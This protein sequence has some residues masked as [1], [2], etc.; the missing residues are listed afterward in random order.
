M[1]ADYRRR[2]DRNLSGMV[3]KTFG[4]S[5]LNPGNAMRVLK[6]AYHQS[7][8]VKR[9]REWEKRGV[10][11]PPFMAISITHR[12]N[13]KCAGCYARELHPPRGE[14]LT[15]EEWRKLL[16]EAREMGVSIIMVLGGEPFSRSDLIQIARSFPEMIF[17]V[18]TNGS[19]FS[20]PTAEW[21]RRAGNIIP[22][23]GIEGSERDTDGRRGKGV[24]A[25]IEKAI[26][27]MRRHGLL[28]GASI[29]VSAPNFETV[30][31]PAFIRKLH[32]KGCRFFFTNEFLPA[33]S[34]TES[35]CLDAPKKSALSEYLTRTRRN[36]PAI[37]V[38]FPGDESVFGGCLSAG[39]GIMHVSAEGRFEPCPFLPFAETNS[40]T[41]TLEEALRSPL[42]TA[43]RERTAG[44]DLSGG[45]CELWNNRN[46]V[47][48]LLPE[49]ELP[50]QP[51]LP[52]A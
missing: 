36:L 11:V 41:H 19:Y 2:I 9:R 49:P 37:F 25:G 31:D 21:I 46:W 18:F 14:E 33:Q 6:A 39:R 5:L 20:D 22:V 48:S 3:W 16:A 28:F 7:K 10:L 32:R 24:H 27:S 13:L 17:L 12:C 40:R 45:N 51:D 44:S 23:I 8:A 50:E 15:G 47:A 30:T 1:Q 34:G 38:D 26:G 4:F 42:F 29:T 43:I 52:A 35:L